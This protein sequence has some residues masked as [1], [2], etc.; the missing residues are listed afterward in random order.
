MKLH[1]QPPLRGDYYISGN[2]YTL[3]HAVADNFDLRYEIFPKGEEH[4]FAGVFYKQ[5]QHPIEQTLNGVSSGLLYLEPTNSLAAKCYGAELS[6]TQ[7]WGRLGVTGNYTYTHSAVSSQKLSHDK[8]GNVDTIVES[9]PL[10]GQTDHIINVSL[11]YKDSKHGTFAQFAYEYQGV[12]LN[13]ISLYYQS[14][15]YQRPMN[16]LSFSVEQDIGRHFTLFGK[17]NNLLNTPTVEY[18]QKTLEVS[19]DV[20]KSTYSVGLR[21]GL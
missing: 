16:T 19:R 20:Y 14:D 15:Y 5:I 3:Q 1:Q 21:Y 18:V 8:S 7:Y 2:P 4:L 12:T 10:Q 9:R 11:L 6:F 17:F 13:Q